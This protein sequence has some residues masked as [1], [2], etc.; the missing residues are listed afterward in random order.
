MAKVMLTCAVTGA[1]DTADRSPH[2]PVTPEQIAESAIAAARAGATV[3]HLHVR[4]PETGLGARAPHLYRETVTRI[5]QSGVDVVLNLTAGMGG[6]LHRPYD[7]PNAEGPRS[8]LVG[9][10]ERFLHVLELL[11]EICT[12]DCGT[13]NFG[14]ENIVVNRP[15]DLAWMA[16]KAQELG[17][18]PELECF[19]MGQVGHALDLIRA[20]LIEDPP[21]FQFVL[22]AAG[23]APA[24]TESM[25]A[26]RNM[27]PAG[28]RWAAFGI[29]RQAFPMLAQAALLGGWVRIGLEDN[30]YL[31][32]GELATNA[33]LV[34]KAVRILD[35]LEFQPMTASEAREALSLRPPAQ[36]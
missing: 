20:G 17:V 6:N 23:G 5:R 15:R 31:R 12:I 19:D 22:G 24:T 11:P 36:S 14:L 35:E 3:V 8:D 30:L 28:A 18:K 27:L 34:E 33:Q 2:V 16:R 13:M 4:D 29:S 9:S 10:E 7:D 21:L 25:L 26:L 32:R 1:G